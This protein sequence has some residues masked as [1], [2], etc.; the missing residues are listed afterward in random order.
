MPT[1]SV[2]RDDKD[3]FDDFQQDDETQA[4]AFH[5]MRKQVQAYNGEPVDVE[6]LAEEVAEMM[7]PKLEL[8]MYR[9]VDEMGE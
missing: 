2:D 6:Q 8:S 9:V 7:G 4:E 5:R 1:V 3:W